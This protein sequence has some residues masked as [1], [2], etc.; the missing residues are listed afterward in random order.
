MNT[1]NLPMAAAAPTTDYDDYEDVIDD[2]EVELADTQEQEEKP[3]TEQFSKLGFS[4]AM[5][6]HNSELLQN[7]HSKMEFSEYFTIIRT[8]FLPAID[9]KVVNYFMEIAMAEGDFIVPHQKLYEFGVITYT[10]DSAPVGRCLKNLTLGFD[11]IVLPHN[12]VGQTEIV[13]NNVVGQTGRGGSNKKQYMLTQD[14]F[15]YCLGRAKNSHIYM[16]YFVLLDRTVTFH[17]DYCT[18]Y[19]EKLNSIKDD[20]IDQLK[21]DMQRVLANTNHIVSQNNTI[22]QQN[23]GLKQQNTDLSQQVSGISVQNTM[24]TYKVDSLV[25]H[26]YERN[27]KLPKE[28]D[29]PTFLLVKILNCEDTY[30]VYRTAKSQ[31]ERLLSGNNERYKV[32]INQFDP[33]PGNHYKRFTAFVKKELYDYI[34]VIKKTRTMN[35]KQREVQLNMYTTRPPIYINGTDII[36]NPKLMTEERLLSRF[37]LISTMRT[38]INGKV[39]KKSN[40]EQ[41]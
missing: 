30:K 17:K 38:K 13:S 1:T 2:I 20:K 29:Q 10:D 16:K 7:H 18:K 34:T 14:A 6:Q 28:N 22:T 15:K 8:K 3:S 5:K 23:E 27:P 35:Q 21:A 11:Y 33:N 24:L 25:E 26:L 37:E 39:M 41:A 12:V 40:A 4:T 32:L 31:V 36:I 9:D 19:H